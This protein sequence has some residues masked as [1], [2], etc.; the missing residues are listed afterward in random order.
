MVLYSS[1]VQIQAIL[2]VSG[3]GGHTT[4]RLHGIA[5]KPAA[6]GALPKFGNVGKK[7]APERRDAITFH[8][9]LW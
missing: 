6:F 8:H 3:V 5:Y 4:H 9:K 7:V 1:L 2:T